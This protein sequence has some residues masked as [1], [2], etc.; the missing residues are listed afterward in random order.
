MSGIK[1]CK[2]CGSMPIMGEKPDFEWWCYFVK[3]SNN[4]CKSQEK[5]FTC[6]NTTDAILL[7]NREQ[8]RKELK[9]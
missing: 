8:E 6:Q 2:Y 4:N 3:C 9:R 7:W 1:K 5:L